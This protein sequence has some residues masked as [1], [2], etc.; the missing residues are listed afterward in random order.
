M[1]TT[2]WIVLSF[3][4]IYA[5]DAN[6]D[7]I[8][9]FPKYHYMF[10]NVGASPNPDYAPT[11]PFSIFAVFELSFALLSASIVVSSLIGKYLKCISSI[12]Y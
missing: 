11:I 3:S 2:V 9:G 10:A 6:G 1:I 12:G 5:K 7:Q 4:L 8:L